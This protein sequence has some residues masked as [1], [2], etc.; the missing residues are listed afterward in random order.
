M[1]AIFKL[2]NKI[3]L[4]QMQFFALINTHL[5]KQI[6]IEST[7]MIFNIRLDQTESFKI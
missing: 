3:L 7:N 4:K 1:I 2:K 6:M 5:L